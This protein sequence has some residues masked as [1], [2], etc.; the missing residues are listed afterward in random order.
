MADV[1]QML[2]AVGRGDTSAAE[3][4]LPVL[5]DELRKLAES[6][7]AKEPPGQTLQATALVHEAYLRLVGGTASGNWEN[8]GHFFSAAAEAMR[9]ILVDR[10]RQRK[11]LKRGGDRDRFEL[12]DADLV[13]SIP[14]EDLLAVNDALDVLAE[15]EPKTAEVV[16]LH[17][18]GGLSM[19]E[20]GAALNFSSRTAAKY[21][22]F[23]KASLLQILGEDGDD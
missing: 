17:C 9:R 16:K 11:S 7:L 6:R 18:F 1:T 15:K 4:L 2:D 14:T 8:R 13:V 5:Y 10:A 3:E 23:A 12:R 21:W 20:I 19:E 22:A